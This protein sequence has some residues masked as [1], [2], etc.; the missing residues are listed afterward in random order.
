MSIV[1]PCVVGAMYA[2]L[3]PPDV[4][5]TDC[6][7]F[8]GIAIVKATVAALDVAVDDGFGLG[9]CETGLAT[10]GGEP[11]PPLQLATPTARSAVA[12]AEPVMRM[13]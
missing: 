8:F 2:G 11:P 12:R 10:C 6:V 13:L 4:R 7:L 1:T 9:L 5:A 3:R